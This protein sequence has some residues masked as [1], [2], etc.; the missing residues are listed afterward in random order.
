MATTGSQPAQDNLAKLGGFEILELVGQGGMGKVYR[1]RQLSLDRIVALKVLT[2]QLAADP[3]YTDSFLREARSAAR[4]QHPNIVG[5]FDAG[6]ADGMFYYVM[7]FVSGETLDRWVRRDGALPESTALGVGVCIA[8]ALKHAWDKEQIMHRDVKPENVMVDTDGNVKLCDLGLAKNFGENTQLSL[9]GQVFGTPQYMSPEQSRA[10]AVD[11]RTDI[12]SLGMTLYYALTAQI[13]FHGGTP[14]IIMA[15]HMTEQLA[16]P[17]QFNPQLSAHTCRV[18][19]KMLAKDAN[20]RYLSWDDALRDLERALAGQP[21]LAQPLPAGNS[22]VRLNAAFNVVAAAAAGSARVGTA[23]ATPKSKMPLA[24]AAA[25]AILIIAGGIIYF[26]AND[27]PSSSPKTPPSAVNNPPV[28]P[29]QNPPQQPPPPVRATAAQRLAEAQAFIM[30]NPQ[31]R[32]EFLQ[33]LR[34][35]IAE[36]PN[37][38]EAMTAQQLMGIDAQSPRESPA[39]RRWAE[40]LTQVNKSPHRLDENAALLESFLKEFPNA[41]EATTA[42]LKLDE[43]AAARQ[44]DAVGHAESVRAFYKF[45]E[46]YFGAL[47]RR[48]YTEAQTL[49]R[50]AT[51][52]PELAMMRAAAEDAIAIPPRVEAFYKSFPQ[53]FGKLKGRQFRSVDGNSGVLADVQE[54]QLIWN[55]QVGGGGVAF[56]IPVPIPMPWR[57]LKNP[58]AWTLAVAAFGDGGAEDQLNL[59]WFAFSIRQFDDAITRLELARALGADIAAAQ[60][61]M[62]ALGKPQD[63]EAEIVF[64]AATQLA[65]QK[66]WLEAREMMTF[67]KERFATTQFVTTQDADIGKL[68]TLIAASDLE[69]RRAQEEAA[70]QRQ[71]ETQQ[72]VEQRERE[73]RARAASEQAFADFGKAYLALLSRR[74]YA[75]AAKLARTQLDNAPPELLKERYERCAAA[76]ASLQ[77]FWREIVANAAKFKGR[78]LTLQGVTGTLD[79]IT[80][81]EIVLERKIGESGA[82]GEP[83]AWGKL[84]TEE[85]SIFV[86]SSASDPLAAAWF[87]FAEG[88]IAAAHSLLAKLS[89]SDGATET[90]QLMALLQQGPMEDSAKKMVADLRGLMDAQKWA[91]A[92]VTFQVLR[93]SYAATRTVQALAAE[94]AAWDKLIAQGE[95]VNLAPAGAALRTFVGHKDHVVSVAFSPDGRFIATGSKDKSVRIWEVATGEEWRQLREAAKNW[96]GAMP[97]AYSPDGRF[98][99]SGNSEKLVKLWEVATSRELW[100][101]DPNAG[102]LAGVAVSPDGRIIAAG[103]GARTVVLVSA[104]DGRLIRTLEGMESKIRDIAFSA[105]GRLVVAGGEDRVVRVWDVATGHSTNSFKDRTGWWRATAMTRDGK[106]IVAASDKELRIFEVATG[107]LV[108]VL[109]GHDSN[110]R[111]VAFTPDGRHIV[112]GA[113]DKTVRLWET[114]TGREVRVMR[115]HDKHV[116]AV[117]VSPDGRFAASGGEDRTIKLWKLWDDAPA[118]QAPRS[119]VPTEPKSGDAELREQTIGT[120]DYF[121]PSG[122]NIGGITYQFSGDGTL[123]ISSTPN[124]N[125]QWSVENGAVVVAGANGQRDVWKVIQAGR[126]MERPLGDGKITLRKTASS[127]G[128][129]PVLPQNPISQLPD[130]IARAALRQSP[131]GHA[132]EVVK[133][134]FS[135]D[136]KYV[137]SAS[138]DK[139]VRVWNP[140]EGK[141]LMTINIGDDWV[142]GMALSGDGQQLAVA[143]WGGKTYLYDA[144]KWPFNRIR[145]LQADNVKY[146]WDVAIASKGNRVATV[147]VDGKVRIWNMRNGEI[148]RTFDAHPRSARKVVFSPD[149]RYVLSVGEEGVAKLF[150]ISSGREVREFRV[151]SHIRDA[152]F[153]SDMRQ[154]AFACADATVRVV[155]SVTGNEAHNLQHHAARVNA[156]AFSPDGRYILSGSEDNT[157]K[158]WETAPRVRVVKTFT[159]H[160]SSVLAVGFSADGKSAVSGGADKSVRV[161]KLD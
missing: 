111:S 12:Y 102:E 62:A 11:F 157:V 24:I 90:R 107:Q 127:S 145:V 158:L 88:K 150:V 59:A 3:K 123:K 121:A 79:E 99:V 78:A 50:A 112:S 152:A 109:K 133:T 19:E 20:N 80:D 95:T 67:L 153:S 55:P 82:V 117:A 69:A 74:Q 160:T 104:A 149:D 98:L 122:A 120:W 15:R 106:L 34:A 138:T 61:A 13:P 85:L 136:G 155:D 129:A 57:D 63:S 47:L 139:T 73:A 159:G 49:A 5:V 118:P 16:D 156:V 10:D 66:K 97:V 114:A 43:I 40:V 130:D 4:L 115:G 42:K 26:I 110:I 71:R 134:L 100:S 101:V 142:R 83:I 56:A 132:S 70:A 125:Q 140:S 76:A 84:S 53:Q 25:V 36:F 29:A 21:P 72:Q 124:S 68:D 39:A 9:S 60:R 141:L 54:T 126:E 8:N 38:P 96:V 146:H 105:D 28:A 137:F 37:S 41:P 33:L 103:G 52:Q 48:D 23:A 119:S 2:P 45:K 86:P 113:E 46:N 128:A 58:D 108:R 93:E 81:A 27:S 22:S 35:L 89:A 143:D 44:L 131:D 87:Q 6:K 31:S 147:S 51:R 94:L 92:R 1:A 7:E 116:Y 32:E 151:G 154:L 65:E 91:E 148:E 18:L 144:T 64:R 30:A 77:N 135:A 75:D 17:R 161:W 14:G